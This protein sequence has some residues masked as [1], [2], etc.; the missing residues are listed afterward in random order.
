MSIL[1]KL[2]NYFFPRKI[3]VLNSRAVYTD[4]LES[5][6]FCPTCKV[7]TPN[8]PSNGRIRCCYCLQVKG[9]R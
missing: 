9:V 7:T 8:I 4:F 6:E 1:T 5:S 2:S 3:P